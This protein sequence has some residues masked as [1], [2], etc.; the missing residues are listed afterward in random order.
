M[1]QQGALPL[2]WPERYELSDYIVASCNELALQAI[3]HPQNWKTPV[4]IVLGGIASGKTH[5][6]RIFASLHQAKPVQSVE[7]LDAALLA[8]EPL[9]VIDN[10]DD[11]IRQNPV[12][13]EKLFHLINGITARKGRLLLTAKTQP[14]QWVTLPD[15]LSRLQASSHLSLENPNED[16]I[17]AAYQKLFTDRSLLVDDKVLDYLALRTE[18]SFAGIKAVVDKLDVVSLEKSRKITIPL[19]QSLDLF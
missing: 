1:K 13:I 12:A 9:V 15:L 16:M 2:V 3:K 11:L 7:D 8:D 17:K 18:R 6:V 19:I 5:L 10:A 4:L 14:A